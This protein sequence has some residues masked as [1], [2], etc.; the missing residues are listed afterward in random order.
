[1]AAIKPKPSSDDV[2]EL[3][4]WKILDHEIPPATKLNILQIT[5]ELKVSQTPVREALRQLQGDNLVVAT[6]NKGY[7]TTPDLNATGV[8]D[9]FE[10]RLLVEPWAA[11][12]AASNRLGNPAN[13]LLAEVESFAKT[14][15]YKKRL[16]IEHD[17]RFHRAI[18]LA[19]DNQVLIQSYEQSHCH[20]HLFRMMGNDWDWKKS[21]DE[22]RKIAEAIFDADPIKAEEAM[23][24]HLQGSYQGFIKAMPKL[25]GDE[26]DFRPGS[27]GSA[28]YR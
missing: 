18:M 4:R 13:A 16:M 9:L 19:T 24:N 22:H 1:M 15:K 7:S 23:K 17:E 11:R 20:L 2:Y 10:F 8:R 3:L 26:S 12:A 5:Q 25:R 27:N 28:I 14:T 21:V 6:A